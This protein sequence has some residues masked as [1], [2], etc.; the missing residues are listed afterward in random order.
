MIKRSTIDE[1]M[2]VAKVDEVINDYVNLKR[3]GA[4]LIGLCPF[5]NEKT[6]SF[7]VSPAKNLYK[8]FGCGKGGGAVNFLMEHENFTY[9]EAL[10]Y[11]AQKYNIRIEEEVRSDEA[12]EEQK[13]N[14]SLLIISEMAA[15]YFQEQLHFSAEGRSI[16]LSYFKHRGLNE[17][18]MKT[19]GLGY[20]YRDPNQFK[21]YALGK[22]YN[23]DLL[24]EVG[25][26]SSKGLDF[27][28]ERV[29]FPFHNLSGKVIGFGG[30]IIK[31]NV[32]APKYLNSPE[33]PIY[34]K[35]K[36]LYGLYQARTSIRKSDQCILVEGYTDVLALHQSD[37]TNVV[38]SSGTS[39]TEQQARLI[40]RFTSNVLV[41][42]DGDLAGEKAAIRG[43]NIFLEQGIN[44]SLVLLPAGQ[45]P[46]SQVNE[47]GK[48]AFTEFIESHKADFILYQAHKID[49]EYKMDPVN[50]SV[51]IKELSKSLSLIRDQIKRSVYV[52]ECA[53]ILDIDERTLFREINKN[54]RKDVSKKK[55]RETSYV[56]V[57]EKFVDFDPGED[58]SQGIQQIVDPTEYQERDIVR[59][60]ITSGNKWYDEDK[61]LN[62]ATYILNNLEG[63]TDYFKDELTKIILQEYSKI[64]N[65]QI[66][67]QSSYWT[68]HSNEQVRTFAVDVLSE[69]YTYAE[70]SKKGLELQT[71]KPVEENH[72]KD[73]YQAIL[74]FK[75]KKIVERIE[76]LKRIF[77][78]NTDESKDVILI[79]AYQ[80][81]LKE[82]QQ[83]A[84]ELKV[85]VM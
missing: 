33:S 58:H 71:Q 19:F 60:L 9:P 45:D 74:R 13:H 66:E 65:D 76:E 57:R 2:S 3:R 5:H 68:E 36:T 26:L 43:L 10:R 42:F 83:L 63:I 44:V 59:V 17:Q 12:L 56:P 29:I 51:H 20:G 7:T 6:P 61:K 47:L 32:K 31:D 50:K 30:R 8:C 72:V 48:S 40:K 67:V 18:T 1:I 62:I 22:G 52:K 69:K 37:I 24:K 4:N 16:G 70:W 23:E 55:S 34:N 75:L 53:G 14:E 46:D 25:L 80:K 15:E 41:I 85:T 84:E 54:I 28:R 27:F 39:L 49:T 81:L 78:D 82:R 21:N 11:L 35:R 64:L 77:S 79:T 38:A 73:S